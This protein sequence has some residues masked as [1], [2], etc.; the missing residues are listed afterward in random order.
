[1]GLFLW[2]FPVNKPVKEAHDSGPRPVAGYLTAARSHLFPDS[3][4]R[5]GRWAFEALG[6]WGTVGVSRRR[7]C[8]LNRL[9]QTS[10][11]SQPTGDTQEGST[12]PPSKREKKN[13]GQ[14]TLS[15]AD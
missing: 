15:P 3:R 9:I 6:E 10:G 4:Q 12:Y 11:G 1:M 7:P 2:R 13:C 5:A 14:T 8:H